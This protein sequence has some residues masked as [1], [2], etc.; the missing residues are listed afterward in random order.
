[1]HI[2]KIIF[3]IINLVFGAL[4]PLSYIY[5]LRAHPGQG[6]LLWGG[7]PAGL[8][9]LY[10][11]NIFLAALGY[12][13][14]TCFIFIHL[15]PETTRIGRASGFGLFNM[16]YLAIL[17]PSALWMSRTF[18]LI[19]NPTPQN[20]LLVRLI[21]TVVGL[22]AVFLLWAL[23]MVTPRQPAWAHTLALVGAF[24][25]CL[26]TAVLDMLVWTIYYPFR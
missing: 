2:Q 7:V 4:V 3:L 9:P 12:L 26:Q 14:F 25:F 23:W 18:A 17:I 11:V 6:A 22:A 10:T 8:R 5:E 24:F 15:D 21:L 13:A 19:A 16:L 20:W 1:M